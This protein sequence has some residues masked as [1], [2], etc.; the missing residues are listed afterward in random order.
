[1]ISQQ[2]EEFLLCLEEQRYYDAHEALEDVWFPLRF[3]ESNE[4]KLI[5][6]FIN[7][8]VSFEL[9][10][11]GRFAQSKRVWRNY[12]KYRKL[13][14]KTESKNLNLYYQLSRHLEH[15]NLNKNF[16]IKTV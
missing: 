7:A 3:T 16:I 9:H 6:G 12:L 2:V 1:M 4:V 13:L 8:S 11:R 15:I 10:K 5:K 14:F